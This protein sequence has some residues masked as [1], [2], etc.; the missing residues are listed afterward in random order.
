MLN[1]HLEN[2]FSAIIWMDVIRLNFI[3]WHGAYRVT[4]NINPAGKFQHIQLGRVSDKPTS[5]RNR[6]NSS[7]CMLLHSPR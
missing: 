1:Q 4:G 3:Y 2:G 5:G 6:R 7:T